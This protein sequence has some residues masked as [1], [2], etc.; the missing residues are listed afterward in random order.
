MDAIWREMRETGMLAGHPVHFFAVTEST[1]TVALALARK[2]ETATGCLV[3]AEHQSGGRGRLGRSWFSPA[4]TGLYF[5]LLFRPDL[6]LADLPRITLAA[7]LA[8]A[9]A[10]EGQ[11]GCVLGLKW[12]NDLYL[13]GKKC[14]GIL[15]EAEGVS[16]SAPPAVVVGVGLN[17]TTAPEDFVDDLAPKATS[18]LAATGIACQRGALLAVI[19][20]E[21]VRL[22]ARLEQGGFPEILALWRARDVHQGRTVSWLNSQGQVIS[23]LSQGP[24]QDGLLRIRDGAG[25]LHTVISGDVSLAEPC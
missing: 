13:D 20:R 6:D 18:L 17:V 14:G 24:G 9:L 8:V 25:R 21:L 16:G 2:A 4:G 7:G 15:T 1:N 12:P 5:S 19:V 10:I 11:T 22:V 3:V 23:G